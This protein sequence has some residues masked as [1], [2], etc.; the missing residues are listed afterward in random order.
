MANNKL[1]E[2]TVYKK[3]KE[4]MTYELKKEIRKR[5]KDIV[6]LIW[7]SEIQNDYNEDMLFREDTLKN[8][9]YFHLRNYLKYEVENFGLRI[10][11][12]YRIDE[13]GSK[14]DIMIANI[15]EKAIVDKQKKLNEDYTYLKN[16]IEPIAIFELK[17]K[18]YRY[19]YKDYCKDINK[20]QNVYLRTEELVDCDYY[21]CFISEYIYDQQFWVEKKNKQNF[22]ITELTAIW[23]REKDELIWDYH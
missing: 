12:E 4:P 19:G 9:L 20:I 6:K 10:Y 3:K 16:G 21:L 8:A 22:K 18:D 23:N 11:T 15:N 1:E 5:I 17:F 7:L 2:I 13:T 14:A